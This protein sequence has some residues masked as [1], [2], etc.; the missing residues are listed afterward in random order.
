MLFQEFSMFI[1]QSFKGIGYI[2][3]LVKQFIILSCRFSKL[4]MFTSSSDSSMSAIKQKLA[5][6]S[7][8]SS[9]EASSR[10]SQEA[11]ID[12]FIFVNNSLLGCLFKCGHFILVCPGFLHIANYRVLLMNSFVFGV[13]FLVKSPERF[14]CSLLVLVF[15]QLLHFL[16]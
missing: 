8:S 10:S 4:E 13:L 15:P 3:D 7:A 2:V 1:F 9:D 5:S 6:S 16:C 11:I 12:F 14:I